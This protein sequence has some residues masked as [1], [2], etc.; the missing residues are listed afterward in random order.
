MK[1]KSIFFV[2][3]LLAIGLMA[4]A[5]V[6][7]QTGGGTPDFVT[8]DGEV[9]A[10]ETRDGNTTGLFFRQDGKVFDVFYDKDADCWVSQRQNDTWMGNTWK[11]WTLSVSD[12]TLTLSYSYTNDEGEKRTSTETYTKETGQNIVIRH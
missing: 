12:N 10:G 4:T 11:Q 2:I 7:A 3:A 9:W 1:R 6:V 5:T 8:K